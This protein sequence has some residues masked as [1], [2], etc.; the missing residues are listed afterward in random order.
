MTQTMTFDQAPGWAR[1]SSTFRGE[2]EAYLILASTSD[3]VIS[4]TRALWQATGAVDYD[5]NMTYDDNGNAH[6]IGVTCV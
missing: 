1:H 6:W 3:E 4:V 5:T 2:G